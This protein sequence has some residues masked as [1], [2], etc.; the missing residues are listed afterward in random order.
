MADTCVAR[1]PVFAALTAEDQER[2][3]A[4]ARPAHL[5][6]GEVASSAAARP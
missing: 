2:V 1:V 3:A 5:T 4:L 6:T